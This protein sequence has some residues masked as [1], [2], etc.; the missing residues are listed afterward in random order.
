MMDAKLLAKYRAGCPKTLGFLYGTYKNNLRSRL[1]K[2]FSTTSR[3]LIEDVI[4]DSFI[5]VFEPRVRQNLDDDSYF[6]NFLYTVAKNKLIKSLNRKKAFWRVV[7][8]PKADF[9]RSINYSP[10]PCESLLN[11]EMDNI[12]KQTLSNFSDLQKSVLKERL[13]R[14][15]S[16]VEG[17]KKH[18]ISLKKFCFLENS[19][20]KCLRD[21]LNNYGHYIAPPAKTNRSNS[22]GPRVFDNTQIKIIKSL[23]KKDT[24]LTEIASQ[25]DVPADKVSNWVQSQK[26]KIKYQYLRG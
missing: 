10:N 18:Q 1:I 2:R 12:I 4:Q 5:D 11:K 8:N 9:F 22:G 7:E 21:N 6:F 19:A 3:E 13:D 14:K 26:A 17:A 25:L 23:L 16:Q 15:V 24:P 20:K